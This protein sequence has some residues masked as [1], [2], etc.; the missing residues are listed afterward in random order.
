MSRLLRAELLRV[1]SRRLTWVALGLVLLVVALA[2]LAVGSSVRPVTAAE[3]TQAQ[4][5]YDEAV[6]DYEENGKTYEQ[7]CLDEGLSAE[8]C[9]AEPPRIE[10]YVP[11]TVSTFA[12]A[13][14][15]VVTVT[16]AFAALGLLLLA[17]SVTGAE[18]SSGA[19]ANWLTFVPERG[20]V[21][22]AKLLALVLVA[23]VSTAAVLALALGVAALV[24]RGYGAPLTGLGQLVAAAGRGVLVGVIA[25][26]VGFG[27]AL[28]T[29]H[30]IAAAGTVLGYLILSAVL[31][32][33]WFTVPALSGVQRFLP[34]NNLLALL[35]G[36][37]TY[38][39][40][41]EQLQPDGTYVD[42]SVDHVISLTHGSVYRAV[43]V[44]VLLAA[45]YLVFRRRDVN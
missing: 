24:A 21:Y 36:K 42:N 11:R 3:R 37:H 23:A 7:Q 19:M 32:V 15:L 40:F 34:E 33:V 28:I 13:G 4:V 18:L 45:S 20:R 26:A 5:A 8:D 35:L 14:Q 12:E 39:T 25:A 31:S 44:L 22:A 38:Y 30:T 41:D 17:A 29:R 6:Q 1:R 43:A 16:V 9:A 10:N 27:I 2:Q